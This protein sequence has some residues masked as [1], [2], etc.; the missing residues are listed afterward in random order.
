[1]NL[2]W[3]T[4]PVPL[5]SLSSRFLTW[6]GQEAG[7]KGVGGEDPAAITSIALAILFL[8]GELGRCERAGPFAF[9]SSLEMVGQA[10]S[11]ERWG[12]VAV[13][14]GQNPHLSGG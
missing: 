11:M 3:G 13:Q 1:M 8:P 2:S 7:R 5:P 6:K 4:Y 12:G 14:D 10:G 9:L